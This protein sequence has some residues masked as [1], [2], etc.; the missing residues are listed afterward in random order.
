M[1]TLNNSIYLAQ[2]LLDN[3]DDIYDEVV[4]ACKEICVDRQLSEVTEATGLSVG[5]IKQIATGKGNPT[6]TTM[7]KIVQ[8]YTGK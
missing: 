2:I 7:R 1:E 5:T 8:H 6:Y 4:A 3:L